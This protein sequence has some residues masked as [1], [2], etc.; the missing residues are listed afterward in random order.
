M[1]EMLCRKG[2]LGSISCALFS[3]ASCSKRSK[4][5]TSNCADIK[6]MA[7]QCSKCVSLMAA[8]MLLKEARESLHRGSSQAFLYLFQWRAASSKAHGMP[9]CVII[10]ACREDFISLL[11]SYITS[12]GV[13]VLPA[14]YMC[15]HKMESKRGQ[16]VC[17]A[18]DY[19]NWLL[20]SN[21]DLKAMKKRKQALHA[22]IFPRK[23]SALSIF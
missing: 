9:C 17:F 8:K 3:L 12:N 2:K 20:Q 5:S 15:A 21:A 11:C 23:Q 14:R 18:L 6:A 13:G 16:G 7:L 19:C 1:Q 10:H 4:I 22:A